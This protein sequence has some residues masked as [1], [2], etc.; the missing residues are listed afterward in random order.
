MFIKK[1]WSL[2]KWSGMEWN[3][4]EK[5]GMERDEK[6]KGVDLRV[7]L[8]QLIPGYI[9]VS[10]GLKLCLEDS[11]KGLKEHPEN[12]RVLRSIYDVNL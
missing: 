8:H 6:V 4:M 2:L 7:S 12:F 11:R 10:I 5:D 9:Q 3:V 1:L